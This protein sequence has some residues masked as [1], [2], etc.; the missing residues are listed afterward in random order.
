M[1]RWVCSVSLRYAFR[2]LE[3]HGQRFDN[4]FNGDRAHAVTRFMEWAFARKRPC[5]RL[6]KILKR[7]VASICE[8][9]SIPSRIGWSEQR[10]A[11]NAKRR[12][13]V[14]GTGVAGNDGT[15]VIAC[16]RDVFAQ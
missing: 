2:N 16:E 5:A 10:D 13:D 9:R 11:W 3:Q 4:S 15:Y 1:K 6:R 8:F 14:H 7:S 12:S